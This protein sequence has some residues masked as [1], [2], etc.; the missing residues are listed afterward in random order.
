MKATTVDVSRRRLTLATGLQIAARVVGVFLGVLVAASLARSLSRPAFGELSL[1]L[2]ILALAGSVTDLG[3]GRIAVREMARDPEARPNI[4]G[5]LCTVELTLSIAMAVVGTLVAFAL[6]R[7]S[8]A[9]LMAVLV[10]VGMP[11]GAVNGLTIAAQAR[12]RPELVIIP[13]LVQSIVWLAAVL[14]LGSTHAALS[15]YGAGFLASAVV[16]AGVTLALAAVVTEVRF[17][18]T[19][20]LIGRLLRLAWPIGLAGMFV[21]AYYRIDGV[22]LFHYRGATA[23]AYYSAAYRVI[24]VIQIA[25]VTLGGV[26]LPLLVNAERAGAGRERIKQLFDLA[27]TGLLAVA[28]PVALCGAILA[29]R[30]IRLVYGP[31]FY[32]SVHLLQILLPAF[33]PICLGYVLTSQLILYD[34]LRPYIVITFVAATVNILANVV[35][36]PRY[37]AAAAAWTTLG[38]ELLVT[39][40]LAWLVRARVGLS[41]P[42]RR[43]LRVACAV[44]ITGLAVW[45]VRSQ[46]LVLGFVVA[47]IVYPPCLIASRG[48]S[49]AEL[50]GLLTREAAANA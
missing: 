22:L 33:I 42:A 20:R 3:I 35:G 34:L 15:L 14:T 26:L 13:S 25:P 12:L 16:Q 28:L 8:Q 40:S 47:A 24:D 2:T 38:T 44:A 39:T 19:R 1:A 9:R 21:T 41:L 30:I 45:L 49:L 29:P 5:A 32:P 27:A 7:G 43:A 10:M 23:A 6:M 36:L 37:G 50:R 46:P 18:G 48:L 31:H 4:V 11:L 17:T